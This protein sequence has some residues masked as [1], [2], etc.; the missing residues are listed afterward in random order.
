MNKE[1][2]ISEFTEYL[3]DCPDVTFAFIFGSFGTES[4]NEHLSDIDLGVHFNSDTDLLRMG[5]MIFDMSRFTDLRIDFVRLNDLYKKDANFAYE[6]VKSARI[7]VNKDEDQFI[8]FKKN[9][10]LWYFDTEWLRN[11]NREA[12]NR[13]IDSGQFGM[14]KHG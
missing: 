9:T 13:R 7:I 14:I 8:S 11:L 4:F 3:A 12:L 10:L 1:K 5:K 6:A 2:L